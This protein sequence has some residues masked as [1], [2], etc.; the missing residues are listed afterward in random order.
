ME[1]KTKIDSYKTIHLPHIRTY[2]HFMDLSKLKGVPILGSAYTMK[3]QGDRNKIEICVFFKDIK[4]L[5]KLPQNFPIVAHEIVHVIDY[6]LEEIGGSLNEE[7]EHMAYIMHYLLEQL[8][9]TPKGI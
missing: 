7:K 1:K 3:M 4:E 8:V 2:V 5:V 6:I 9:T